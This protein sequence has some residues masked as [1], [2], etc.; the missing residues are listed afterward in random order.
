MGKSCKW[1]GIDYNQRGKL[2][3]TQVS[4]NAYTGFAG[5]N[6]IEALN[7]EQYKELMKDLKKQGSAA[8]LQFG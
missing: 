5:G 2:G 3:K 7:T 1:C 8:A 6:K 4:F